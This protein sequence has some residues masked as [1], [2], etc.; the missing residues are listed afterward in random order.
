MNRHRTVK[1]LLTLRKMHETRATERV[2]A[3]EA[4]LRAAEQESV[5]ARN[6]HKTHMISSHEHERHIMG[7]IASKVMRPIELE[8]IQDSLNSFKDHGNLLAKK[9]AKAQSSM[10]GRA[11]DLKA[12][13]EHLRQK[14][15]EHLKLETYDKELTEA[16]ELQDTIITENNDSDRALLNSQSPFK[17]I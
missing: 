13:Q 11:N 14:Q 16:D 5:D 2:A 1:A 10:R 4:A 6:E 3:S 17:P 9:V 8:N 12:A 15:R 7:S